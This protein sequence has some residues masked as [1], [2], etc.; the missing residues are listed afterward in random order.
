[1][2]VLL[3]I[4]RELCNRWLC[5]NYA[6]TNSKLQIPLP[7]W[8][9]SENLNS[10]RSVCW[11]IHLSGPKSCSHAKDQ[12]W[13]SILLFY[14][15]RQNQ[16]PWLS[17]HRLSLDI[18]DLFFWAICSQR[19]SLRLKTP[20]CWKIPAQIPHPW[21]QTTVKC[22]G[23]GGR[24]CWSFVLISVIFDFPFLLGGVSIP[25]TTA[26]MTMLESFI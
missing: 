10:R 1:M 2:P 12:I 25:W 13:W 17:I 20:P 14:C 6:S 16:R 3:T 24:G 8:T 21:T 19:W 5:I 4:K 9:P 26:T 18:V 23:R 15:K 11:T 7:H 22:S